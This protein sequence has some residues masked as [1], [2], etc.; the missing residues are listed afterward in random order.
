MICDYDGFLYGMNFFKL[1]YLEEKLFSFIGYMLNK[2]MN[3][4]I[5][6]Y[7]LDELL[8]VLLF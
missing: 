6:E 7:V 5:Y 1:I 4:C 8:F 2:M 3:M